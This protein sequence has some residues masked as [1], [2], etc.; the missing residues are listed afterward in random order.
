[1]VLYELT[2]IFYR[3]NGELIHSPKALG[4]YSTLENANRAICYYNERPGF[5]DNRG[6]FSIRE[7]RVLGEI[8]DCCVFEAIVYLHSSDYSFEAEIELGIYADE[9]TAQAELQKYRFNNDSIVRAT[10]LFFEE[11]VNRCLIDRKQWTEGFDIV[12]Y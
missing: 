6:A 11:I 1:M 2:H 9:P 3:Y 5:C 7:R 10:D 4:L 12:E 8:R